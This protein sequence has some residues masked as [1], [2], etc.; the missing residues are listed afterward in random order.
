[1]PDTSISR[2]SEPTH[3]DWV[4]EIASRVADEWGVG[5]GAFSND[6]ALSE[7][8][9]VDALSARPDL[10][11]RLIGTYLIESDFFEPLVPFGVLEE[12]P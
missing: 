1:M 3:A 5:S 4:E 8:V 9:L 12:T 6:V 10:V 7:N 11:E 2:M